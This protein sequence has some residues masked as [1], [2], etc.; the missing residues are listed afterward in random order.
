MVPGQ[1]V[2]RGNCCSRHRGGKKDGESVA[3]NVMLWISLS[4]CFLPT[5]AAG[6]SLDDYYLSRLAPQHVGTTISGIK[7]AAQPVPFVR[8]LTGVRHAVKGDWDQLEPSTRKVLAKVLAV[9]A[10]IGERACTPVG[11]HFTIHYATS[12]NDAPDATD[13]NHNNVPDWVE[14]VAGVFEYVYD[15]EVNKMGYRPPPNSMYDVYL[16]SLVSQSAYGFTDDVYSPNFPPLP[17]TSVSSY[18]TIDNSFTDP[19]FTQTQNGFFSPEQSLRVTAA[20]EFHHA[21]QFGY[22]YY[23]DSFFGEVAATWMEDEVYNSVNQLYGYLSYYLPY[24]GTLALNA[25]LDGGSEYGR[26]LFSRYLT[27]L[28][29]NRTVMRAFWEQLSTLPAPGNHR[30]IPALPVLDTVL[31]N[32]LGNNFFGFAKR[33]F[34]G[35]W[36]SHLVDVNLIEPA[37]PSLGTFAVNTTVQGPVNLPA[38]P[39]TFTY[40]TYTP[41][42]LDGQDLTITLPGLSSSL[43]VAAFKSD[44]SGLQEYPYN[45]A[46]HA[47]VIPAFTPDAKVFLL[48]CNNGGDMRVPFVGSFAADNSLIQDGSALDA[49]VLAVPVETPLPVVAAIPASSGGKSGCFIATAA[50]GSYLHPKVAELRAF[51]DRYL[52]SNLPGRLLVS[53]Y[54]WASP[55]IADLIARHELLRGATRLLLAPVVLVVEHGRAVLLLLFLVLFVSAQRFRSRNATAT[56]E[57]LPEV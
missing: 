49:N 10:L 41:S 3:K 56:P 32:N 7:S 38:V 29:G 53:L 23:F 8:S 20:H 48:V 18:I 47:I 36:T 50:Y 46:T 54:Y 22:N 55:P 24:T 2:E 13:T 6:G 40:Y 21:I 39:Y 42:A 52:L 16:A 45:P 12:G 31:S 27:E 51:R 35:G 28:H 17:V 5:L 37:I 9:P 33:V 14:K 44:N 57:P 25:P 4:M 1:V 26:W 30:D 15:V 11:G 43:A 19:G 34:L